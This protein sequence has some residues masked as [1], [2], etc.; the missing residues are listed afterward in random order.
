MDYQAA[1]SPE[2][3]SPP[4]TY[5]SALSFVEH[6]ERREG[7]YRLLDALER[8]AAGDTP[9]AAFERATHY[10]LQELRQAWGAALAHEHLQ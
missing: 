4:F 1:D 2:A 8:L 7:F 6:L 10:S 9:E 3:W 5:P